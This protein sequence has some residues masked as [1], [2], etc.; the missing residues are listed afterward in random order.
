M[1]PSER[2]GRP[3]SPATSPHRPASALFR[4]VLA[5]AAL[6]V[7]MIPYFL[8]C[9]VLLPWRM[10]RL[11]LGNLVGSTTGCWVHAIVGISHDVFGPE[12]GS[13]APALFVQNHTGTLDLFLAM[14]LC[15]APGSGALKKEFLRVPFIGLGYLLSGHLLI[16]R[17]NRNRAIRSMTAIADLVRSQGISVWMLPEGTRSRDGRLQPFKKGFGHLA[18]ATRLPIVPVVVHEGHKF[19]ARGMKVRPGCVSVEVLPPIPTSDWTR[20]CLPQKIAQVEGIFTAALARH[21]RPAP[22][23]RASIRG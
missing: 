21:Q 20:D 12:P 23:R 14:Q 9:I 17:G 5:M 3:T 7:L 13:L 15:P 1:N 4:L 19:W 18:L 16:D 10:L 11:R 2:M 22:A 8:A 6:A